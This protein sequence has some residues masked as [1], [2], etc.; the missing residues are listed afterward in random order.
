MSHYRAILVSA[1][2]QPVYIVVEVIPRPHRTSILEA[3]SDGPIFGDLLCL[4][5]RNGAI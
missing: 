3:I 2:V 4:N 5:H 1:D